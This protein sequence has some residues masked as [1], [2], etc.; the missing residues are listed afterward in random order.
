MTKSS[1]DKATEV[2]ERMRGTLAKAAESQSTAAIGA[3]VLAVIEQGKPLSVETIVAFLKQEVDRRPNLMIQARNE[4][5]E[6]ELL[7]AQTKSQS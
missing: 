2:A 4:A 6:K 7:A 1:E 5:A 3:A